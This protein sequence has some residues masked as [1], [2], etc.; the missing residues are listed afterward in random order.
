[1]QD[2][3]WNV[4]SDTGDPVCYLIYRAGKRARRENTIDDNGGTE[5]GIMHSHSDGKND[6][7]CTGEKL[8][9]LPRASG[10]CFAAQK[11]DTRSHT[12]DAADERPFI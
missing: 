12:P 1:M 5:P 8:R 9:S 6:G 11:P 2:E 3:L 7:L 10:A 4:F